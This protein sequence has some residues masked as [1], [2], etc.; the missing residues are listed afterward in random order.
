MTLAI[1][2]LCDSPTR[3]CFHAARG[4]WSGDGAGANEDTY[5]LL[6]I[7]TGDVL[8]TYLRPI[9]E[10]LNKLSTTVFCNK[11]LMHHNN[12]LNIFNFTDFLAFRFALFFQS[13]GTSY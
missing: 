9:F 5:L 13:R 1:G 4:T 10:L 6:V 8:S 3:F 2:L 11:P 7:S 12:L